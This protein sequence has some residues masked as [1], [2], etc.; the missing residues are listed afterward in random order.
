MA[1]GVQGYVEP[2]NGNLHRVPQLNSDK[3]ILRGNCRLTTDGRIYILRARNCYSTQATAQILAKGFCGELSADDRWRITYS[4]RETTIPPN[5]PHEFWQRDF[6]GKL[7]ADGRWAY[8]GTSS[9]ETAIY[10]K[11]PKSE[12]V[13][14]EGAGNLIASLTQQ[15]HSVKRYKTAY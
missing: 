13:A 1:M 4:E 12:L 10:T 15:M 7:S 2:E 8:K 14:V 9:P 3:G 11:I 6:E 5:L